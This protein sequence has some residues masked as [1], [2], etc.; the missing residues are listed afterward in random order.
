MNNPNI[1]LKNGNLKA[2]YRQAEEVVEQ[3]QNDKMFWKYLQGTHQKIMTG[4]IAGV[5]I[6]IKIDSYFKDKAIID[7]KCMASLDLI[8]NDK[9]K[10]KQN[11][12]DFYRVHLSSS[13]IS[14]NCKTTNRKTIAIYYCSCDKRKI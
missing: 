9:L 4:K 13:I 3:M 10:C 6:K 7:L 11:F 1:F 2:E 14:R 8:W 5:P 12:V